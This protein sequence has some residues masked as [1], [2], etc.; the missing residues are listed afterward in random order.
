M[1]DLSPICR[2]PLPTV[3]FLSSHPCLWQGDPHSE[4]KV[5]PGTDPWWGSAGGHWDP[6]T[7][8]DLGEAGNQGPTRTSPE[9]EVEHVA[10]TQPIRGN[11]LSFLRGI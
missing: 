10:H 9:G 5:R 4:P 11:V 6:S 7:P 1:T 3:E 2:V 8:G